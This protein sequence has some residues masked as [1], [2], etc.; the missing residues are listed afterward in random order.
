MLYKNFKI[1]CCLVIMIS[2]FSYDTYAMKD[3]EEIDTCKKHNEEGENK[4]NNEYRHWNSGNMNP[5]YNS[6]NEESEYNDSFNEFSNSMLLN[7]KF[8]S[9]IQSLVSS[10]KNKQYNNKVYNMQPQYMLGSIN[11]GMQI[12]GIGYGPNG[13]RMGVEAVESLEGGKGKL[14]TS[15]EEKIKSFFQPLLINLKKKQPD[16][17]K[18]LSDKD[19]ESNLIKVLFYLNQSNEDNDSNNHNLELSYKRKSK[20]TNEKEIIEN[21]L[22]NGVI[23]YNKNGDIVPKNKQFRGKLKDK[24]KTAE[25]R[26][27]VLY[28]IADG[29][30]EY[31]DYIL[32]KYFFNGQLLPNIKISSIIQ[33]LC[34]GCGQDV[35]MQVKNKLAQSKYSQEETNKNIAKDMQI[36]MRSIGEEVKKVGGSQNNAN[37]QINNASGAWNKNRKNNY[38]KEKIFLEVKDGYL[39]IS[40]NRIDYSYLCK[41]FPYLLSILCSGIG[42]YTAIKTMPY[43]CFF[44]TDNFYAKKL[45]PL[46]L[47]FGI[48][49]ILFHENTFKKLK[50]A[51]SISIIGVNFI[52]LFVGMSASLICLMLKKYTSIRWHDSIQIGDQHYKKM[53]FFNMSFCFMLDAITLLSVDMKILH[54]YNFSFNFFPIIVGII[55]K[56]FEKE[57]RERQKNSIVWNS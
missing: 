35:S 33:L 29:N 42:G 54:Y 10:N 27:E 38:S 55:C 46:P 31:C 48:K 15:I 49:K 37:K 14:S 18:G 9:S 39:R 20:K 25:K 45:T 23:P 4:D 43:D 5:I 1:L 52:A 11:N 41:Y 24:K 30:L 44:Y 51:C 34:M 40:K 7:N 56:M 3:L 47:R 8:S 22:K 2:F 12:N 28:R 53:F 32:G 21:N 6:D 13:R 36:I 50:Y 57:I 19:L 17:D 16:E 26:Y